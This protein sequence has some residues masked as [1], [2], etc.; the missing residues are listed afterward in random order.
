V[1]GAEPPDVRRLFDDVA[2]TYDLLNRLL[3]VGQDRRWR[4]HTASLLAPAPGGL[5]VD[6]CGGTGDLALEVQR[7]YP[8]CRVLLVDFAEQMLRLVRP[9]VEARN[10]R[11]PLVVAGDAC[12]LPLADAS[13]AGVTA[14]FGIRNLR[15]ARAGLEEACRVLRPG[16]RLAMLE[17]LRPSSTL[18]RVEWALL[19]ALIPAVAWCVAPKRAAAYR[20]LVGSIVRFIDLAEMNALLREIGFVD[21]EVHRRM[22]GIATIMGATRA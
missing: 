15:S 18:G 9:K 22:L 19:R 12:R 8:G 21:I 3:S 17:F 13:C 6:L 16:G 2:P 7:Q 4:R 14:A 10:G 5:L 11:R 1:T 20:Y